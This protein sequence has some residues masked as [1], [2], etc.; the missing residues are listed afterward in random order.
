MPQPPSCS[1]IHCRM[2]LPGPA[3]AGGVTDQL[4]NEHRSL[5]GRGPPGGPRRLPHLTRILSRRRPVERGEGDFI[6]DRV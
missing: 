1:F 6:H 5:E 3:N 2:T 4:I